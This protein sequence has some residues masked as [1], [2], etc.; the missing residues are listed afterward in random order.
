MKSSSSLEIIQ[1]AKDKRE[2][3]L[4]RK[5]V[6]NTSAAEAKLYAPSNATNEID[7]FL[8]LSGVGILQTLQKKIYNFESEHY[9][10]KLINLWGQEYIDDKIYSFIRKKNYIRNIIHDL[11]QPKI[12]LWDVFIAIDNIQIHEKIKLKQATFHKLGLKSE[13]RITKKLKKDLQ[14]CDKYCFIELSNIQSPTLLHAKAKAFEK[15]H[16]YLSLIPSS[17]SD[18][19]HKDDV[20]FPGIVYGYNRH[21]R[22]WF[23]EWQ[24]T[25][26]ALVVGV[27]EAAI[28]K[29][30]GLA[31]ESNLIKKSLFSKRIFSIAEMFFAAKKTQ[32]P[33]AK[34]LL[35][36]T[37]LESLLLEPTFNQTNEYKKINAYAEKYNKRLKVKKGKFFSDRLSNCVSTNTPG[38]AKTLSF[39]KELYGKRS[40]VTHL[41]LKHRLSNQEV[42]LTEQIVIMLIK[43]LSK[44]KCK[45]Q[46]SALRDLK[47]VTG[48]V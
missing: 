34:L 5:Q 18:F 45:T 42:N 12:Y 1:Y 23:Q 9:K 3:L 32:F 39:L 38:R 15:A 25:H 26:K 14:D 4:A 31:F 19:S 8:N 40:E 2:L 20:R 16:G 35:L 30:L 46:L 37:V 36:V 6:P 13:T 7:I 17:Y 48:K 27:S 22:E 11:L 47:I 21:T 24:L 10:E 44:T 41:C 33:P 29:E 28:V 43:Q